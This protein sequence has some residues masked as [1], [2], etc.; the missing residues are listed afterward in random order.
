MNNSINPYRIPTKI[1]LRCALTSPLCV[2]S[3]SLF[4]ACICGL[5]PKIQSVQNE[6][7]KEENKE[8]N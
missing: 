2:P 4:G 5:W 7:D 1:G 6:D 3:F 8:I